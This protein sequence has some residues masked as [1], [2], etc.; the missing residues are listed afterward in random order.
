MKRFL[1]ALLLC[2]I[3]LSLS[4]CSVVLTLPTDEVTLVYHTDYAD[5]EVTLEEKEARMVRSILN[6]NISVFNSGYAG[7]G[8][9]KSVSIRVGIQQFGMARDGCQGFKNLVTL[10]E[11]E[12]SEEGWE[13][14]VSL[15]E[16][17]GGRFPC[18]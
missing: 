7:C 14:I 4:A 9:G 13:Y 8:Y 5:F 1:A 16:K 10:H 2:A 6:G 3:L 17:Y 12:V 11:F 18:V 15:F